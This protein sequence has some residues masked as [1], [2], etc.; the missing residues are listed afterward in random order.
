MTIIPNLDLILIHTPVFP[1]LL[2]YSSLYSSRCPL[3]NRH[4]I[5]ISLSLVSHCLSAPQ[6][7]PIRKLGLTQKLQ[8]SKSAQIR[9]DILSLI[10]LAGS[11]LWSPICG[12]LWYLSIGPSVPS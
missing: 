9:I 1:L 5:D 6:T 10:E 2:G 3:R 7:L 11:Q 8:H 12:A 4:I